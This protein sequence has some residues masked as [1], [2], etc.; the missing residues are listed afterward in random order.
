MEDGSWFCVRPSGTE[1]KIKIYYGVTGTDLQ[2]AQGMLD[3][4][5]DNVLAVV[6]KFL[7]E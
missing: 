4:L 2:N 3:K 7:F 1:P 6:E 5:R